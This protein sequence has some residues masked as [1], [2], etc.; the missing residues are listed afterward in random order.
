MNL[1][2]E[3]LPVHREDGAFTAPSVGVLEWVGRTKRRGHPE[4]SKLPWDQQ[5]FRMGLKYHTLS[6]C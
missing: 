6:D 5:I 4:L 1:C 3:E 2:I